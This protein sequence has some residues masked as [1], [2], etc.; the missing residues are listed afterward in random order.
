MEDPPPTHH[1]LSL[2]FILFLSLLSPQC[3]PLLLFFVHFHDFQSLFRCLILQHFLALFPVILSLSFCFL[4]SCLLLYLLHSF[5]PL[6][7][8]HPHSNSLLYKTPTSIPQSGFFLET[9]FY[10][11]LSA[12]TNPSI[13]FCSSQSS[14]ILLLSVRLFND[15]MYCSFSPV[16]MEFILC[17]RERD[18]VAPH[19]HT[20]TLFGLI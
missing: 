5:V 7:N 2:S 11:F 12:E 6:S 10:Q 17:V 19:T 20:H 13:P 4:P 8:F 14:L 18:A 3:I 1:F 9:H 15:R 16:E